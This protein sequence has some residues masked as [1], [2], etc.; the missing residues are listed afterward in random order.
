MSK[1]V[2]SGIVPVIRIDR[3]AAVALHR[4]VYDA[5]RM[6][7]SEGR[8]RPGQQIPSS[9]LL[10]KE[11]DVSRLPVLNAYAQLLAEGYLTARIGSGTAVSSQLPDRFTSTDPMLKK[12]R[13]A[14]HEGSRKV[15]QRTTTLPSYLMMP[16]TRNWGA[17]GVGQVA[18]DSFPLQ[19]WS[20]IVARRSKNMSVR[21]F[22][23]G[24]Q[25]GYLPLRQSIAAYLRTARSVSCDA[26]QILIVSGSQ[27]ALEISAQVLVD[28][29]D[30]VWIEEPGYRF[31]REVFAL[32]G[33]RLVAVPVDDEGLNVSAGVKKCR[34][35]RVAIVTPSH[36]FPL[37]VTMSAS[38]RLQLLQWAQENGS[39]IIEDD[40]DSE[41][42]YESA[43][44]SSL[45]GLDNNERVIY[46]G[47]FSK[48]LFPSLRI[49]YVVVPRDLLGHFVAIRRAT[50]LGS[51]TLTQEVLAEFIG[52]GHFER[53][54]RR[55]RVLYKER[56]SVLVESLRRDLD[57]ACEVIGA[58]AGL[59]LTLTL[60]GLESDYDI[61][62]RAASQNLWV[63]PLSAAYTGRAAR[64]G[65]ILGFGST[66]AADIPA[67]VRKLRGVL[68]NA[69]SSRA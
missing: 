13:A 27:Q 35:A 2:A 31:S 19:T 36:Q 4:Q 54:I 57:A 24:D 39:W 34:S 23:Y 68:W 51:P 44:I 18:A 42:R 49:G 3:N 37:G 40:Y 45:Q 20:N 29:G 59:H 16:W 61:A 55:M 10:A 8:L 67:A 21:S 5:V 46:I 25:M 15:A 58:E 56:R 1:R 30:S 48:V 53:H 65:L 17:F 60:P 63:W 28:P 9:R 12:R 69:G 66:Q 38:R 64:K 14:A 43:P 62:L 11:L 7:I 50:D 26:D 22:G 52:E 47:T 33:S 32:T 41:Y 6:A